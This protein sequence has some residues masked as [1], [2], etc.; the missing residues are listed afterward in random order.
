MA[1]KE[2]SRSNFSTQVLGY[3]S[4]DREDPKTLVIEQISF[5]EGKSRPFE[6]VELPGVNDPSYR[7]LYDFMQ[8]N[9]GKVV[10]V[11]AKYLDTCNS[12]CEFS[13]ILQDRLPGEK[14]PR[15]NIE[16]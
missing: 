11:V 15:W 7:E 6:I 3:I 5:E 4:R 10:Y 14:P 1:D 9:D 2:R 12:K 8:Q 13:F 16:G